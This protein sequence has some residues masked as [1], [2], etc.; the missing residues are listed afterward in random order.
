MIRFKV[1]KNRSVWRRGWSECTEREGER[2]EGR[3][4][5]TGAGTAGTGSERLQDSARERA[6]REPGPPVRRAVNI[7]VRERLLHVR[8]LPSG[9]ICASR[10]R[11]ARLSPTT[12]PSTSGQ[13]ASLCGLLS[14]WGPGV[15]GG[16]WRR[17]TSSSKD[18]L[19]SGLGAGRRESTT[20]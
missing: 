12:E 11:R 5:V 14:S 13:Y 20:C 4:T 6:L 3:R 9:R 1:F 8:E 16:L 7:R 17:R 19:F 2:G 10:H 18:F 15:G